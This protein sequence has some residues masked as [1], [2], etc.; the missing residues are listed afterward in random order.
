MTSFKKQF[1]TT[2]YKSNQVL[3]VTYLKKLTYLLLVFQN[4]IPCNKTVKLQKHFRWP[5][6]MIVN[7]SIVYFILFSLLLSLK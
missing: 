5:Q 3:F 7:E 4:N 1:H 6:S 2:P